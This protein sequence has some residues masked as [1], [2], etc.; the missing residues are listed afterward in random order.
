VRESNSKK[1]CR[2]KNRLKQIFLKKETLFFA[3]VFCKM[4]FPGELVFDILILS[5]I[6]TLVLVILLLYRF[7]KVHDLIIKLKKG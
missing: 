3:E 6:V 1:Q 5:Q 2:K 7:S 4:I